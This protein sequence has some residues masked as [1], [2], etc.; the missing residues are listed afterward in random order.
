MIGKWIRRWL[1]AGMI[2]YFDTP[3]IPLIESG[4]IPTLLIGPPPGKRTPS[5][6]DEPEEQPAWEDDEF[7]EFFPGDEDLEDEDW[8]EIQEEEDTWEEASEEAGLP[9]NGG[10]DNIP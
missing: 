2:A 1:N 5:E 9:G 6:D 3:E 10:T 8:E 7:D 4:F